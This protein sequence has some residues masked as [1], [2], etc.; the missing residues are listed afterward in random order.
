[1]AELTERQIKERDIDWYCLINGCP[2]HIASMGGIIPKKFR[3]RKVLRKQQD[4]VANIELF[5]DARLNRGN[6]Q[7]QIARGYEYLQ[8]IGHS[9]GEM[10]NVDNNQTQVGQG[11]GYHPKEMI[12]E[13]IENAFGNNPGF[14]Y[15]KDEELS[16]R[17]F[18]STFAEKARRGFR[19]YAR[20]GDADKENEYILIAE[21]SEYFDYEGSGLSLMEL[22]CE[23]VDDGNFLLI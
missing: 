22:E 19:S 21:P 16:V 11:E 2:T 18:A 7:T 4:F 23:Q 20:R 6:I 3:E 9:A 1:M 14:A 10:L 17:L 13:A 8:G 5:A 15:L 12:I